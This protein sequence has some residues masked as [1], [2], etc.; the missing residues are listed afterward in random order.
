MVHFEKEL[1]HSDLKND[2]ELPI[3]TSVE[4]TLDDTPR[5]TEKKNSL[6]VFILKKQA[7]LSGIV[8]NEWKKN[9]RIG[10]LL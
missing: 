2:D 4:G 3:S 6:Y 7:C 10:L 8:A 1:E 5:K 9:K